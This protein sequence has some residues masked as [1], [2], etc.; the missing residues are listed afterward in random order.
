LLTLVLKHNNYT[1]NGEHFLQING[2][3]M[4]TK[5]A[6]SYANIFMGKLEKLIMLYMSVDIIPF[7][8]KGD[9]IFR[10]FMGEF[11]SGMNIVG[12]VKETIEVFFRLGPLHVNVIKRI[13]SNEQ[14]TKKRI[15]ELKCHLKKRGYNNASIHHCFNKASGIDRKYLI[16]YKEKDANNRV[17]FV[18]ITF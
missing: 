12:M 16:K 15:G 10:C 18:G 8:Q 9:V 14:T 13:C 3:A 5:M 17:P 11:Y 1:F 6:P 2:T 4:G 7:S